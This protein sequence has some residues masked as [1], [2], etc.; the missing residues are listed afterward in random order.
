MIGGAKN[1][2]I[3]S[4]S[5]N[6]ITKQKLFSEFNQILDISNKPLYIDYKLWPKAIPLFVKTTKVF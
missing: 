2:D 4:E 1:M 6:T 3:L 5:K